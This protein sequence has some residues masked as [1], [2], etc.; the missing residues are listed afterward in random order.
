MMNV[1]THWNRLPRGGEIPHPGNIQNQVGWNSEQPDPVEE[2]PI[3]CRGTGLDDLL[4]S[5]PSQTIL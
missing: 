4:K 3:H 5:L 1:V 2:D